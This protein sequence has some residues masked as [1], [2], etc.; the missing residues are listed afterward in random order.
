[1]VWHCVTI[2]FQFGHDHWQFLVPV[3]SPSPSVHLRKMRKPRCSFLWCQQEIQS[4]KPWPL[5]DTLHPGCPLTIIKPHRY[6]LTIINPTKVIQCLFWLSQAI[7]SPVW[8]PSLLSPK[9]S[10]QNYV[11]NNPFY[12]LLVCVYKVL[13]AKPNLGVCRGSIHQGSTGWL[14]LRGAKTGIKYL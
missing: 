6:P 11:R 12:I 10:L 13:T 9:S 5:Y 7:F 2:W 8:K 14:K 3:T 1:M 4:K